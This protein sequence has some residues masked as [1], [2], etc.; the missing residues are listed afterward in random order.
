MSAIGRV[1]AAAATVLAPVA[2]TLLA[3]PLRGGRES[4]ASLYLLGVVVA[5][6]SGGLMGGLGASVLAFLGLNYFFT[7][8][9]GT[10]RVGKTE[11]LV[12]LLVFLVVATVVATLLAR[13]LDERARATRREREA[14]LLNFFA[15]KLLSAEPLERRLQ[16]L[17]SAL[18]PPFDLVRCEMHANVAGQDIDVE[19]SRAGADGPRLEVPITLSGA[20]L[21][22]LVVIRRAGASE[23]SDPERN[24]LTSCTKQVAIALERARLDHE[25]EEHRVTSETN[26]LRAALFSSVTH[27]LRTPLASIKASVTSMLGDGIHDPE[28]E[29]ELL[30]TVL[31]E[32]DRLNRLVGN[33]VDLA[34]MRAG[35]LTPAREPTAIEDV[36]ESVLHRMRNTLAGVSLRTVVRPELPEVM[37]DPVQIDQV[38][39]NL[40]ENAVRF[41]PH[42]GD[43]L[44]SVAAWR[45]GVQVR[46][47]DQGPGVPPEDR[48]RVFE[49]FVRRDA[50]GGRGGSGLGLAIA[51]AIVLAHGGRIRIEGAPS[52]GT[53]VVFEL[54]MDGAPVPQEAPG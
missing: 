18:L 13:A 15:T 26:Q 32:T 20:S 46:V 37:M 22:T 40:L 3:L 30:Q 50:G 1:R 36:L 7:P 41:S 2:A 11:D 38:F 31:E 23:L 33:I 43:V 4:A 45:D 5:A 12:A 48:E 21:G 25:L 42:G 8:P 9:R 16:D 51:R 53:A 19:G 44:V 34:K 52:G 49:P 54:P 10:F 14:N 39:T 27:D 28:Q 6:A 17:A 29:R 47:S 24:L 35:A